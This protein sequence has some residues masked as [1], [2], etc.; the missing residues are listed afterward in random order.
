MGTTYLMVWVVKAWVSPAHPYSSSIRFCAVASYLISVCPLCPYV[1]YGLWLFQMFSEWVGP[2]SRE[3]YNNKEIQTHLSSST[4]IR[5]LFSHFSVLLKQSKNPGLLIH[6]IL[7]LRVLGCEFLCGMS[8]SVLLFLLNTVKFIQNCVLFSSLWDNSHV[9]SSLL[10]GK[11]AFPAF[12]GQFTDLH[13]ELQNCDLLRKN[14]IYRKLP[15]QIKILSIS[16]ST[17]WSVM[18]SSSCYVVT[19]SSQVHRKR[20]WK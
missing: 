18:L 2:G 19:F 9:F 17:V 3:T 13:F 4:W 5:D 10:R 6:I 1:L 12:N 14:V 15:L 8:N 7:R 20:C 11:W 16:K